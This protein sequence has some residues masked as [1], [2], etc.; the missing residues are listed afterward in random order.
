[1]THR[2]MAAAVVVLSLMPVPAPGQTPDLQG[3]WQHDAVLAGHSVEDGRNP[4]NDI[5][6]GDTNWPREQVRG[7]QPDCDC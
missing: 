6:T 4:A 7:A 3:H 2:V 5:I 1:M